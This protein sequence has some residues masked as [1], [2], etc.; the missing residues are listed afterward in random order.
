MNAHFT[1]LKTYRSFST[2]TVTIQQREVKKLIAFRADYCIKFLIL[3]GTQTLLKMVPKGT[4]EMI[5]RF[6]SS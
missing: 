6:L 5:Y 2:V 3:T 4:M 1:N